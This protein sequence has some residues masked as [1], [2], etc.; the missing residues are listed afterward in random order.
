M[1]WC[2]PDP[3]SELTD[4]GPFD[5]LAFTTRDEFRTFEA[6]LASWLASPEGRFAQYYAERERLLAA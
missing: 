2:A 3:H 5:F 6:E 4:D 1:F